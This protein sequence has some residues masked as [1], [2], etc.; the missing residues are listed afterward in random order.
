MAVVVWSLWRWI[1]PC[2]VVL[3]LLLQG[4]KG[5]MCSGKKNVVKKEGGGDG[6]FYY[7]RVVELTDESFDATIAKYDHIL[8]DFYAPWC[9]HCK[10]LAPELDAAAAILGGE[11]S[12]SSQQQQQQQQQSSLV[13]AKINVEKYTKIASQFDISMYPT[14]KFFI[15]G[16]PTDYNGPRQARAMVSYLRRLSAPELEVFSDELAFRKFLTSSVAGGGPELPVF[17]GFGLETELV[18]GFFQKLAHKHRTRAWFAM[19][20]DF[21]Q[22]AMVDF[23]FDKSPAIVVFSQQQGGGGGELVEDGDRTVFYGPFEE[24]DVV[25][26]V[27]QNL[28]PLVT[29]VVSMEN[30]KQ[31]QED[32]RPIALAILESDITTPVSKSFLRKMKAAAPAHRSFVFAYVVASEWPAFIRPFKVL[33]KPKSKSKSKSSS[34][35]SK[36]Q[37]LLPTMV[38]WDGQFYVC[39]DNPAAFV[40]DLIELE[41]SKLLQGFK[42]RSIPRHKLKGPS[43]YERATENIGLTLTYVILIAA[44]LYT[45]L[46]SLDWSAFTDDRHVVVND[47]AAGGEGRPP[48][49]AQKRW[50][51]LRSAAQALSQTSA[52]DKED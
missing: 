34:S 4:G 15:N 38:I 45:L 43:L 32:G 39:S 33:A 29:S 10:R 7:G 31:L 17:V 3:L 18:E 26:F 41:I 40:G 37:L 23:D 13:L 19:L 27:E 46:S 21:S 35:P 5:G 20:E 47:A 24:A 22:R 1:G 44:I 49:V 28:L 25:E 51:D 48:V 6:G 30:V 52:V 50:E 12:D 9:A 11:D 42:D 16:F 36:E 8:V 2:L 14:L